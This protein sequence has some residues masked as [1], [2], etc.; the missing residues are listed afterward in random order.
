MSQ[1]SPSPQYNWLCWRRYQS[2]KRNNVCDS[3]SVSFQRVPPQCWAPSVVCKL[4][5]GHKPSQEKIF[6]GRNTPGIMRQYSNSSWASA[7]KSTVNNGFCLSF[8]IFYEWLLS[9]SSVHSEC[10]QAQDS[11]TVL[12]AR[13]NVT[14]IPQYIILLTV[15]SNSPAW[16]KAIV[17]IKFSNMEIHNIMSKI[18]QLHMYIEIT[19]LLL[20]IQAMSKPGVKT[21]LLQ[22]MCYWGLNHCLNCSPHGKAVHTGHL[23]SS[24]WIQIYSLI[25]TFSKMT[26]EVNKSESCSCFMF[27]FHP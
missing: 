12:S 8:A 6:Q 4:S 13:S 23:P 19:G 26:T 11:G 16:R 5:H 27:V 17:K 24:C 22:Y 18:H 9:L 3:V 2:D 25:P 14:I 1:K 10:Y 21:E 20:T 7:Y 15:Q